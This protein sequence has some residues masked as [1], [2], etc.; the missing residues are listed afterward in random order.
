MNGAIP[1]QAYSGDTS[2]G[3][4][5]DGSPVICDEVFLGSAEKDIMCLVD[6]RTTICPRNCLTIVLGILETGQ[7]W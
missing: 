5:G 7:R 4:S 6:R 3:Y 2:L 1:G